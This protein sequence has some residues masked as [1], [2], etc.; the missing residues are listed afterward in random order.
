MKQIT[1]ILALTALVIAAASCSASRAEQMKLAESVDV[2][3]APEV[4]ALKG[5]RIPADITVTFPAKY[6][7]PQAIMEV[8]PVLVYEGGEQVARTF[9]YQGDKVKDNYPVI[10]SDVAGNVS[11]S[12]S[13]EYVPGVEKS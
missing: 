3:C 10:A 8:T 2:S 9:T 5:D 13:F 6:F 7:H 4:L 1:K 12:V 11:E